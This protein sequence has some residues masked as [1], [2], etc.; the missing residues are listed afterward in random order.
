M[1]R[2]IL[3]LVTL[4]VMATM[5]ALA[6]SAE[7]VTGSCG[8]NVTYS[9]SPETGV[10]TI[11]GEGDMYTY[12]YSEIDGDS[13]IKVIIEDGVT[14]IGTLAFFGFNSLTDVVIAGSVTRI[15]DNA[16]YGCSSL[17]SIDISNGVISIGDNAFQNC[18]GLTSISIPDS[19]VSIGNYAFE[20]CD[21]IV[22]TVDGVSYYRTCENPYFMLFMLEDAAVETVTVPKETRFICDGVFHTYEYL[23]DIN[24]DADNL[25]FCDID[26]VLFNKNKTELICYPCGREAVSYSIPDSVERIGEYAFSFACLE[27]IAIPD[28]VIAIEDKAFEYCY[29]EDSS[30]TLPY[31]VKYVDGYSFLGSYLERILVD[32]NNQHFTDVDGVLFNKNM[33]EIVCYPKNKAGAS[34]VIPDRVTKIGR[35][36]FR[37]SNYLTDVTIIDGVET[38][39]EQAFSLSNISSIDIPDSVNVIEAGAFQRCENMTRVKIP[40]G[41]TQIKNSTFSKCYSLAEVILPESLVSIDSTAFDNCDALTS[42]SIPNG[43]TEIGNHVFWRCENLRSVTI[44]IS[45]ARIGFSSFE[46]CHE[47]LVINC[48]KESYADTY[49]VKNGIAVK[50]LDE[51]ADSPAADVDGD[52]EVTLSDALVTINAVLKGEPIDGGDINGDGI[53]S[54]I[55]ILRIMKALA[56]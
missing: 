55:D 41:I 15:G 43:V 31:S 14:S 39:C 12:P 44:P 48:Y 38:I 4:I 1:K 34:Y 26:G 3:T 54:L 13:V 18:I 17:T 11:S 10:L 42:I 45:V 23:T 20:G 25:L 22:N 24:V 30:I 16:F 51:A 27:D 52:G 40:E 5:F 2:I 36:A 28:S 46:D 49:A 50:Y 8:E 6:V 29:F 53:V 37:E 56:A 7:T 33:T 47:D 21:G 19:V 35:Y 9:F 32:E